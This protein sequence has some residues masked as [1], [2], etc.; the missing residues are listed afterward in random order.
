MI[1]RPVPEVTPEELEKELA[2]E[3]P[4]ILIDVRESEE[5]EISVLPGDMHIPMSDIPERLIHLDSEADIVIYC[6]TGSRSA[7]V[8][9]YMQARGFKHVRN[10]ATGINGWAATV[11]PSLPQY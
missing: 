8:V 6:R 11:D 1:P 5:R 3:N 9:A 10:L 4:P 7:H 2:S